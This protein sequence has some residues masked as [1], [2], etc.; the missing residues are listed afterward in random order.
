MSQE[1]GMLKVP[2]AHPE[3]GP[4]YTLCILTL[5]AAIFVGLYHFAPSDVDS[6]AVYVAQQLRK[7]PIDDKNMRPKLEAELR[8][9]GESASLSDFMRNNIR[10]AFLPINEVPPPQDL[11]TKSIYFTWFRLL[12]KAA[13]EPQVVDRLCKIRTEDVHV[14]KEIGL[15]FYDIAE[16]HFAKC[17]DSVMWRYRQARYDGTLSP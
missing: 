4:F 15:I 3:G 5:I 13:S 1:S 8:T 12:V 2:K 7:L 16:T 9:L 17:P 11:N 10:I 14:R 6:R